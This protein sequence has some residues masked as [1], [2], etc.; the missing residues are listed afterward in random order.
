[1]LQSAGDHA[2]S[3]ASAPFRVIEQDPLFGL[4]TFH[5]GFLLFVLVNLLVL[6][7]L[8]MNRLREESHFYGIKFSKVIETIF[9]YE[10]IF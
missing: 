2:K 9:S 3:T 4:F 7:H 10:K 6:E 8:E 1:M 5:A